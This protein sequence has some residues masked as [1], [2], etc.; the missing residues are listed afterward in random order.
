MTIVRLP[1]V[2]TTSGDFAGQYRWC[3]NR[4]AELLAPHGLGL[5]SLVLTTDFTTTAT[6]ADYPRCGRPRREL[7]SAPYPG[8]A[9]ILVDTPAAP[10]SLVSLEAVAASGVKE[11]VNPGWARYDTLTYLPGIKA[12]DRLF[13]AGFGALDPVTQAAVH[14][15]DLLAQAEFIYDN[16]SLVVAA[17]GGSDGDV[18]SLVE[19]YVPGADPQLVRPL[20]E[21]RFPRAVVELRPCDA[22]LRPE[23]LLE[24]VPEAIL[25]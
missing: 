23:F 2:Y 1:K 3:L 11:P 14:D 13:M 16:I 15:G 25:R 6:R 8:A 21:A 19:Y 24:V 4:V 17:A 18:V 22:L 9:G 20:R 12:G 5:D 7:L 10:G